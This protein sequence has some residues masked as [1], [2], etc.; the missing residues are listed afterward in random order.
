MIIREE[1]KWCFTWDSSILRDL[2]EKVLVS[3]PEDQMILPFNVL[4]WKGGREKGR[5]ENTGVVHEI[6]HISVAGITRC[7][8]I[9][10]FF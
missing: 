10:A 5:R 6:L 2:R 8:Y 4:E 7:S 9:Y 1:V 3:M